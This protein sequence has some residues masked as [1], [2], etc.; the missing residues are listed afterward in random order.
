[1]TGVPKSAR[2]AEMM[3]PRYPDPYT[4]IKSLHITFAPYVRDG[5]AYMTTPPTCPAEGYWTITADFTYADGVTES[6]VSHSPC[7]QP[8]NSASPRS[9]SAARKSATQPRRSSPPPITRKSAAW[10]AKTSASAR[11]RPS[12]AAAD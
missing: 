8:M 11:P 5:K 1:M 12:S 3:V 9:S 2:Q 10:P 7:E 4:P 6:L